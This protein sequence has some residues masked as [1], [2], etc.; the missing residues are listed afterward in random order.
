MSL[1]PVNLKIT[2]KRPLL[3]HN[4]AGMRAPKGASKRGQ[5]PEPEV[6]A[7]AGA[8]RLPNGDLYASSAWF[9]GS[10]RHAAKGMKIGKFA[11]KPLLEAGLD[12]L[13]ELI[14]LIDPETGE[15]L[16]EYVIDAQR[17]VVQRQGIIRHRPRL[18]KW[19][20]TLRLT[21]DTDVFPGTNAEKMIL[22]FFSQAGARA[23]IGDQRPSAPSTPG[24]FGTFTV[25]LL[26]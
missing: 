22:E 25:E 3:M 7:E 8:Y 14:P 26:E 20:C 2:G 21:Y 1:I 24:R 13:N 17:A 19:G 10:L 4:P 16:R 6:E 23:G 9:A 5:I 15:P 11:A 12:Y 18:D